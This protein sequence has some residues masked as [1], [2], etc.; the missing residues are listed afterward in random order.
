MFS[1]EKLL[2]YFQKDRFAGY[3]GIDL[4]DAA[5]GSAKASLK[6]QEKHLNG[7]GLVHGGAIFTLADFVF[8]VASNAHGRVSLS[9]DVHI[10]YLRSARTGFLHAEA[11]EVSL[12][13]K[14]AHYLIEITDDS[15]H[16]IA[17]MHGTAYRKKELIDAG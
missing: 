1:R 17:V 13:E 16:K 10:S 15:N 7:V 9:T 3:V 2:Q 8:A 5:P 11:K 6:I 14:L 12:N 4:E